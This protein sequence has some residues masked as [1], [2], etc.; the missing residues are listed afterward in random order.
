L[1]FK[2][3]EQFIIQ[4]CSLKM[5]LPHEVAVNTPN[6]PD[7]MVKVLDGQPIYILLKEFFA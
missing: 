7:R 6:G 3:F 5:I 1:D 4:F 2:G